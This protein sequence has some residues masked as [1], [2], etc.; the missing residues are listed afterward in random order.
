MSYLSWRSFAHSPIPIA[1]F[2]ELGGPAI[3][4]ALPAILADLTISTTTPAALRALFWPIKPCAG[5]GSGWRCS[6]RPRP[7]M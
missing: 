6:S 1:V 5:P 4:M 2:P 7:R 3:K